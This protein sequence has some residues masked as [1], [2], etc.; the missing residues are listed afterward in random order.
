MMMHCG[1]R[2][3]YAGAAGSR[4]GEVRMSRVGLAMSGGVGRSVA[5]CLLRREGHEV[6]GLFMRTGVHGHADGDIPERKK[7]CCSAV[8]AGDARRVADRLDIPFH[9]LDFEEDFGRIMDYFVDEY[10]RGRTPNPCVVCNNWLKFG[11]LWA[12]GK[13]LD[14]DFVATGHYARMVSGE[15]GA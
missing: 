1:G 6:I 15:A 5:A 2:A 13:Q 9:A 3:R 7:G 10:V 11:K 4:G 14:A 12:Y 8:D